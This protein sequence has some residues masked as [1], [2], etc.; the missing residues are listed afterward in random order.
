M[1]RGYRRLYNVS[2][3]IGKLANMFGYGG[4]FFWL[5]LS[6]A[7]AIFTESFKLLFLTFLLLNRR[8]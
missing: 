5:A 4:A 2:T 1:K 6:F 7:V 3:N 8:E